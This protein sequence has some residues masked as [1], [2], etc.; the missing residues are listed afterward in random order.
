MISVAIGT[1]IGCASLVARS[2]G[3]KNREKA[4]AVAKNSIFLGVVSSV[5][6]MFVGLVFATPFMKIFSDDLEIVGMGSVYIK[7][8]MGVNI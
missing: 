1:G 5:V 4:E 3:S 8:I 7:I 2:L 6:F